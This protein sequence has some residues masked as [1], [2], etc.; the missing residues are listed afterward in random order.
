MGSFAIQPICDAIHSQPPLLPVRRPN[1][2]LR[3]KHHRNRECISHEL[4][5]AIFWCD[6]F[7][8]LASATDP[9]SFARA[10]S[11]TTERRTLALSW[12]AALYPAPDTH[13]IPVVIPDSPTRPDPAGRLNPLITAGV[14]PHQRNPHI[15]VVADPLYS[16]L[17]RPAVRDHSAHWS[18][19]AH[20]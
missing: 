5:C 20:A 9:A 8:N 7:T 4:P 15:N 3:A 17:G 16:S 2:V 19:A 1:R 13:P 10:Q 11:S 6:R 14:T 18:V 12:P